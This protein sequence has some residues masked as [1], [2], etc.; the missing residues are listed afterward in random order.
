[1]NV[2]DV[3]QDPQSYVP[4]GYIRYAVD[5]AG[6][7]Q[8][9]HSI[10]S[11]EQTLANN[12]FWEHV[13][14]KIASTAEE[15]RV[16]K[17]S[18]LAFFMALKMIER[19]LL[20]RYVGFSAWRVGRHLKPRVFKRLDPSILKRYADFFGVPM[21]EFLTPPLERREILLGKACE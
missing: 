19:G 17:A 1:M 7:Y 15:V 12:L 2:R 14:K 13:E 10:G 4:K 21:D 18:P 5:D 6:R 11:K 9:V 16:G 20:A 8:T 3:P